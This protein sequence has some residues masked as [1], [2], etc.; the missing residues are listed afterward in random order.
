MLSVTDYL[1]K[2]RANLNQL[3]EP[4]RLVSLNISQEQKWSINAVILDYGEGIEKNTEWITKEAFVAVSNGFLWKCSKV[5]TRKI[6]SLTSSEFS[7][8]ILFGQ[9]S[10]AN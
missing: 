2:L 10:G 9:L 6:S 3:P 4:Y 5:V 7:V 1:Q 8:L